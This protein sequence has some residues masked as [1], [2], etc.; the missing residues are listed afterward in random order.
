MGKSDRW[1]LWV[2]LLSGVVLVLGAVFADPFAGFLAGK[3]G[4]PGNPTTVSEGAAATARDTLRK[5]A[6][7]T[8]QDFFMEDEAV[9]ACE[10]ISAR[11]QAQLQKLIDGGADVNLTGKAGFTL[12]HW[13]FVNDNLEAFRLLLKS[14]AEPDKKL[15]RPVF[16]PSSTQFQVG[17]SILFTCLRSSWKRGQLE[18]FFAALDHTREKDP[19]DSAGNTLLLIAANPLWSG[20]GDRDVLATI[21]DFGV[22]LNAQT[23]DGETAAMVAVSLDRPQFAL[24][25]LEAGADPSVRDHRGKSVGDLVSRKLEL[26]QSDPNRFHYP[27]EEAVRLL[28]WLEK[29]P[30]GAPERNQNP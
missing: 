2:M 7:W 23:K 27:K 10:A 13:A 12:L 11:D 26:V 16:V 17:D 22:D 18:F 5:R 20:I 19:R 29:R 28:E 15:T 21:I 1:T 4:S 8:P 14:G 24:Q 25:I 6:G 9:R 30:A 3:V